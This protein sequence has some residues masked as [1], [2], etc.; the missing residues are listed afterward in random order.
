MTSSEKVAK[1]L[2]ASPITHEEAAENQFIL[3]L[4]RMLPRLLLH[5]VLIFVAFTC[6]MPL[7]WMLSGS[8]KVK[9]EIF[10]VRPAWFPDPFT[11]VNYQNLFNLIPFWRQFFNTLFVCVVILAGQLFFSSMGAY[12]FARIRFPGRGVLFVLFLA[13]MMVPSAVTLIPT[14]IVVRYLGWVNSYM[15][16]IGPVALGSA[17]ATFLLRQFMLTIPTEL[18]EAAR[19]DG[20]GHFA[21]FFRVILPLIR[22][23]LIVLVIIG[24]TFFWNDFLWPLIVI[25]SNDLRTVTVGI[26]TLSRGP[27]GTDWGVLMAGSTLSII[28]VMVVFFLAQRQFIDG[29]TI[30]G[31]K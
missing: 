31:M 11:L 25:N 1:Q 17:Y 14:F 8:F 4:R 2:S 10:N 29:I 18:E 6:L 27:H 5:T 26:A 13:S 22:P 21:I 3:K 20:A 23:A 9:E 15:G 30:T 16:L 12:A 7:F 24:F 19:I 28:P